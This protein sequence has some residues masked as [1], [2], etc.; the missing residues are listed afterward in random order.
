M[1]E[2]TT[3]LAI[4]DAAGSKFGPI[5]YVV[6]LL[7][8]GLGTGIYWLLARNQQR[9]SGA[10]ADGQIEA[11][12]VYK[13]MLKTEREARIAAETRADQFA[14]ELRD[15]VQTLGKLEGQLQAMTAELGRVRHELELMKGQING[16][17]HG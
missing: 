12:S 5:G 6:V 8:L 17:H 4:A 2:A 13:E 14:R 1:P 3:A 10:D 15:A 11:L 9:L 7:I 16:N